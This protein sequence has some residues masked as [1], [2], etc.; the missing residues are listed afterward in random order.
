MFTNRA[1]LEWRAMP[2]AFSPSQTYTLLRAMKYNKEALQAA[3]RHIEH[4]Y[5]NLYMNLSL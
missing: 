1:S 4:S 3:V 2:L 5:V